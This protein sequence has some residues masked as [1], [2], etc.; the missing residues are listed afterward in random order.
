MEGNVPLIE[1]YNAR[2]L[3]NAMRRNNPVQLVWHDE[4]AG[5]LAIYLGEWDQALEI[6]KHALKVMER[7]PV[8]EVAGFIIHGIEVAAQWHTGDQEA[9]LKRAKELSDRAAKIQVVDYSVYVGFFHFMNVIFLALEQ[10]YEQN[11]SQAAKDELM[12]YA[13]LA[14]KIMKA[15]ARVFSAGEPVLYRYK[16]W[17]EWYSGKKEKAYQ[18]WR[19]ACEKAHLIPMYYEEGMSYLA[20]ANHLPADN[21]ERA[22][23]FE[24]A[25]AAFADGGLE[26]WAR[27]VKADIS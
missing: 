16:G 12:K 1:K 2:L 15:Y 5:S 22:A 7:T 26:R 6:V 21:P 19:T 10:A 13:S 3:E 27:I 9:A 11:R 20:L 17:V 18:S 25:K 23:S 14:L 4:W 8:G 24:N